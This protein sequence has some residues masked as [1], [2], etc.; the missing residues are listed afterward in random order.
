ME[1]IDKCLVISLRYGSS[2]NIHLSERYC[3]GNSQLFIYFYIHKIFISAWFLTLS[4][5]YYKWAHSMSFC[6]FL[7]LFKNT[8]IGKQN[9]QIL[10]QLEFGHVIWFWPIR[11]GYNFL[12]TLLIALKRQRWKK[13]F[14]FLTL[15]FPFISFLQLEDTS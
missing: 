14:V 9:T 6:M 1:A 12:G 11:C 15:S 5:R 3:L 2:G 4:S 7:L 8:N 10:L 13:G